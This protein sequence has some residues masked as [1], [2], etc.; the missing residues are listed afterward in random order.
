MDWGSESMGKGD[1]WLIFPLWWGPAYKSCP[2]QERGV[3]Q[4]SGLSVLSFSDFQ[5]KDPPGAYKVCN[6][7]KSIHCRRERFPRLAL[8]LRR[9]SPS[10]QQ[11][12]I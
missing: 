2:W 5:G 3:Q 8:C 6:R 4:L 10:F 12:C 9:P 1:A 11:L 7:P